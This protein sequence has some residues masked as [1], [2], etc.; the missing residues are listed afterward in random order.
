MTKVDTGVPQGSPVSPILFLIYMRD[1]FS[2]LK[3]VTPL[4]YIDDIGLITSLTSLQKNARTLQREV[5]R[6][7]RL[8]NRQAIEFD[9]AKTELIHFAKGKGSD[10]GITLLSGETIKLATK[11]VR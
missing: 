1:L 7:T 8:G 9:L 5:E 4:S 3:D 11:A 10:N 6:L 2:D